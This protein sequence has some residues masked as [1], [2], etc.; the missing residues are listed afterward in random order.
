MLL[1]AVIAAAVCGV[2]ARCAVLV[3]VGALKEVR[4]DLQ[5]NGA[6]MLPN[7]ALPL[8]EHYDD[9]DERGYDQHSKH[10]RRYPERHRH[11]VYRHTYTHTTAQ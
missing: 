1:L 2:G 8:H 6:A 9:Y 7:L 4:A 10:R 11:S 3:V 5:F